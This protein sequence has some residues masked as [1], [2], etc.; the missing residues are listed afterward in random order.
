MTQNIIA[1]ITGYLI[2]VGAFVFWIFKTKPKNIDRST[3]KIFWI[4]V[5]T[6]VVFILFSVLCEASGIS[7]WE[8]YVTLSVICLVLVLVSDYSRIIVMGVLYAFQQWILGWPDRT[9][10]LLKPG[11][12]PKKAESE[13]SKAAIVG[14]KG[15]VETSLRPTGTVTVDGSKYEASCDSG[16]VDK[17]CEVIVIDKKSFALLVRPVEED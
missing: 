1:V 6:A 14:S 17:G 8:A 11:M 3:K 9:L 10:F 13:Q 2:T 16:F 7:T 5:R 12:R 4:G 15:K